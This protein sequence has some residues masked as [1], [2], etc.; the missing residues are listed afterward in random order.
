VTQPSA[1]IAEDESILR[2]ELRERLQQLW[3][4]LTIC[5]EA[6]DGIEA[7]RC[8]RQYSPRI[9]FLD[10][11]MPGL[12]GLEVAQQIGGSCHIVFLTAHDEHAI[13]AFE[14]GAL[15]YLQKPYSTARLAATIDRLQ[16][17]LADSDSGEPPGLPLGHMAS[18]GEYLKWATVQRGDAIQLVATEEI[19]YLRADNKYTSLFTP[20]AEYLLTSGLKQIKQKLDPRTF[21]QIH[22][23]VIVNVSAIRSVSRSFR[24]ALEVSLKQRPETLPVST[25]HAHLFRHL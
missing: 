8:C 12:T 10:I 15:D 6:A 11:Q 4:E 7:I 20:T 9:V 13:E 14:R 22:R 17:R 18:S 1:L 19:C 2:T 5:A 24:G 23:S 16:R 3:P 21:W 25:A